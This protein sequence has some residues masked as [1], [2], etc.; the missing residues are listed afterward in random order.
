MSAP[1]TQPADPR[2]DPSPAWAE[3]ARRVAESAAFRHTILAIIGLAA[4]LV[5]VETYGGVVDE[6]RP[7]LDLVNQLIIIA[8]VVELVVR[9]AACGHRPWAFFRDP[10]NVFDFVI[11]AVCLLPMDGEFAAV[12]RLA[13]V[14]RVLRLVSTVPRLQ[15]IVS[16]LFNAIPSIFYVMLLLALL[17]YVYGVS[18]T[19][20]FGTNDPWHFGTLHVSL[21]SLFRVITLEDWT[22]IMYIQIH[23]SAAYAGY[24][25]STEGS[26][27]MP[28]VGAAFFVSFVLL[29]TMI[30][31]NFFV[32]VV[33]KSLDDAQKD[34]AEAILEASRRNR[35]PGSRETE[36]AEI[37]DQIAALHERLA[38]LV[39][40]PAEEGPGRSDDRERSG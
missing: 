3:S 30:A 15:V 16:S 38:G 22:D 39:A 24:P 29:G 7:T 28:I 27:S 32:G 33:L 37:A 1:V 20:L 5:G 21:L 9:I 35:P 18:G 12:A 40:A 17:F 19:V 36:L 11:V 10:W 31:L 6:I 14:L 26:R 4:I 13:R 8:F 25:G 34:Q 2:L 23:G